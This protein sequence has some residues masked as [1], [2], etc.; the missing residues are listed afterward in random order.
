MIVLSN[1][2]IMGGDSVIYDIHKDTEEEI[3]AGMVVYSNK[4]DGALVGIKLYDDEWINGS[5]WPKGTH[6][7]IDEIMECL[8]FA[9]PN[10]KKVIAIDC[11]K[12]KR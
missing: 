2:A 1:R 3:P 10:M 5:L 7:Y 11:T 9:E 6:H 8:R 4:E 12:V